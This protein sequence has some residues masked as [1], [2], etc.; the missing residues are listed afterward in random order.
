MA[1]ADKAF[2]K[3]LGLDQVVPYGPRPLTEDFCKISGETE[4]EFFI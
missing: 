1:M 2:S 3:S 4:E